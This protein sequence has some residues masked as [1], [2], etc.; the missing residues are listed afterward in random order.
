MWLELPD[1]QGNVKI[2]AAPLDP[3][4]PTKWGI[5]EERYASPGK[6]EEALDELWPKMLEWGGPGAFS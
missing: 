5:R 1:A 2:S 4:S 6:L 3:T